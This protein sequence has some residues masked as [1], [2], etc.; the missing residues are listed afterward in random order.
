MMHWT[1]GTVETFFGTGITT[2]I[3]IWDIYSL[4]FVTQVDLRNFE[5]AKKAPHCI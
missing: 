1:Y 4:E 3:I 2:E 5:S